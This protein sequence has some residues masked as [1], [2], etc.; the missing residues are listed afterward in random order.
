MILTKAFSGRLVL[1][2]VLVGHVRSLKLPEIEGWK[3]NDVVLG[4]GSL[5]AIKAIAK[6]SQRRC[7]AMPACV[8]ASH[9]D[10]NCAQPL[11]K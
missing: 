6:Q 1:I 8:Q 4:P 9:P 5:D 7:P 10:L 11:N 3:R 2:P